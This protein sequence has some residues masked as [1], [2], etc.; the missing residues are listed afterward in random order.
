METKFKIG[1]KVTEIFTGNN[2]EIIA[3]KE[4]PYKQDLGVINSSVIYPEEGKDFVLKKLKI[5][6]GGFAPFVH[7]CKEHLTLLNNDN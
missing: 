5:E 3:D 6:S 2:Y 1:D 4:T 7:A